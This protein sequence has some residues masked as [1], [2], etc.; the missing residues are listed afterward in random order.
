[1]S[2]NGRWRAADVSWGGAATPMCARAHHLDQTEGTH[3]RLEGLDLVGGACY[4]D[5]DRALGH[6]DDLAA[7]DLRDLHELAALGPIGCDLE[8]RQLAGDRIGG[9][10]VADLQNVDELVQLLCHLVDWV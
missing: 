6:V 5:D 2:V 9:L 1:V 10:E 4:L 7:E 3:H 8:Q